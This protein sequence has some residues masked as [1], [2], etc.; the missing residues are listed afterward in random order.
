VSLGLRLK[1]DRKREGKKKKEKKNTQQL[2]RRKRGRSGIGGRAFP[3][4]KKEG[5]GE[6]RGVSPRKTV[7]VKSVRKSGGR[8]LRGKRFCGQRGRSV[9]P[10]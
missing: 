3:R 9:C 5:R 7:A 1:S 6:E 10:P 4:A 8:G 2:L